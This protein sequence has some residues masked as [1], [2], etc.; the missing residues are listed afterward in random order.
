M[1]YYILFLIPR[2]Q[3]RA[4]QLSQLWRDRPLSPM[5]T[6]I[7]WVEYVAKH[8][9]EVN[10][11]PPT[12]HLP[13]YEFFSLDLLFTFT[14]LIFLILV[15]YSIV[16]I[17][18]SIRFLFCTVFSLFQEQTCK[19][20]KEQFLYYITVFYYYRICQFMLEF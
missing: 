2:F 9:T 18:L 19:N 15:A 8:K 6:A 7:Y 5:N 11:K 12:V 13:F 20:K 10:M 4:N 16:K 17:V 3:K 14:S 1:L